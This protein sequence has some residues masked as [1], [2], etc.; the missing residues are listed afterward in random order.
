M[1]GYK[2]KLIVI[3]PYHAVVNLAPLIG[4]APR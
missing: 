4:A 2:E 3:A 1:S